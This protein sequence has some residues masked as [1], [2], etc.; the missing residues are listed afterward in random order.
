MHILY[1]YPEIVIKGGTEKILTEKANYFSTHGYQVTIVTESQMGR[2]LSFVLN[3]S[4]HLIDLGLDF[5][6]QYT[7]NAIRRLFTYLSLM[8]KYKKILTRLLIDLHADF[9]I[10]TMGRS[11][12]LLPHMKDGSIKM[13]EAHMTKIHLRNLDIMEQRGGLFWIV[14]KYMRWRMCRNVS[15]IDAI[16]LLTQNDA[17]DWKKDARTYVIPNPIS[18]Y[19]ENPAKLDNKNVIMVGRYNESKGYDY[20]IPAWDIVHKR[21]P[22]WVLNVFGSGELHDKVV[23][24]IKERDLENTMILHEPTDHIMDEYLKSSISV[25]SSRHEGF[26]L[27][28][29][30]SMACGVPVVSFNCPFGPSTIIRNEEDGLLVEHLNPQ[31]LADGICRLIEDKSLRDVM[32]TKAR[33][34]VLRFSKESVMKQWDELFLKIRREHGYGND[35]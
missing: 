12:S 16:V 10:T 29:L 9:V 6:R 35:D 8:K 26:S 13:A 1:I 22:D 4:V 19:P 27:V 25:L 34:N 32:G 15:K 24:W 5:N 3:P 17:D 14:A 23:C 21:H 18:F 11:L 20:L 2:P 7:Q 30:E 28:I 31:A 33:K